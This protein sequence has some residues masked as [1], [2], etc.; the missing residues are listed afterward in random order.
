MAV[1]K[2]FLCTRRASSEAAAVELRQHA[3]RFLR[4]VTQDLHLSSKFFEIDEERA[5]KKRRQCITLSTESFFLEVRDTEPGNPVTISFKTRQ[6]WSDLSGGGDNAVPV[7]QIATPEGYLAL[8]RSLRL[9]VG[10]TIS[11]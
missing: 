9:T 5:T 3:T 11:R 1:P 10:L 8:L 2:A 4:R 6:G 7:E